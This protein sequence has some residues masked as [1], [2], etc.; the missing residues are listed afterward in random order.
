MFLAAAFT[1]FC[2][3]CTLFA[4]TRHPIWGLYFYIATTFVYPPGRWWGYLFGD[5]RWALLSAAITALAVLFHRGKLEAK[6]IWLGNAPAVIL[7]IYVAWMALQS[8][9]AL[10]LAEHTRG[11]IEFAK[12]LFALWLVYRVVDTKDRLRDLM[13]AHALGCGLLG[14][15]AQLTG[16]QGGRLDGVG[17]PNMDDSNTLGMYLATGAIVAIGLVLTQKGWRRYVSLASLI[18]IV[19][20]FVLANSRGAFLGL[21]AGCLVLAFSIAR[22]YRWVFLGFAMV[23]V[24]GLGLIVDKVFIDRMFTI[25]D[26]ASQDEDADASAR[27]RLVIANAQLQMFLDHP[28]GTGWRGTAVLSPK[29]MEHR[30]LTG[31]GSTEAQRSSHNTFL[32]ALVEQGAP[33]A[34]LYA[35]LVLWVVGAAFRIRRLN[36]PLDDPGLTTL[37]ASLCGALVVVLVAGTSADYLTKEVQFWL[38][39]ALVS[40]F[41]L[42]G[43]RREAAPRG[44]DAMTMRHLPA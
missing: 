22:R 21:V 44:E 3:V 37:G 34:M 20:G 4:F 15:F 35:C 18:V 31:D 26:V 42:S 6:P 2:L 19:N 9:W 17:G 32:T 29:Y 7:L 12:C 39:A 33:G 24:L 28:M 43:A 36:G 41:W 30:W 25:G 5:L 1:F 13:L 27:S 8:L 10:D 23:G 11:T 16:R 14:V 40:M 38:Y